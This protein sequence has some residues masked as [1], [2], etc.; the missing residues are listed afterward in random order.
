MQTTGAQTKKTARPLPARKGHW[1]LKNSLDIKNDLIGFADENRKHYGEIFR[2]DVLSHSLCFTTNPDHVKYILQENNRN[3]VKSFGYEILKVFLGNGLLTSEGDFWRKQRRLAQP[4]FHREKLAAITGQMAASTEKLV[5]KWKNKFK[6]GA[7]INIADE[8]NEVTLDIVAEALFGANVSDHLEEIREAISISNHFAMN[9]IKRAVRIPLWFP[10]PENI[11]FNAASKK[12][13]RIIYGIIEKRR[14]TKGEHNDLLSMLMEAKDEETGESMSD[15]QLRDEV[16]TIFIAGHE[17][18]AIALSWL[19]YLLSENPGEEEKLRREVMPLNGKTLSFEDIPKL[20]YTKQVVEETLRLY[21]PAWI[22]GRR[23]MEDDEV[24]GFLLPRGI[25]VLMLT[26]L[27]HRH[28]AYWENPEKFDPERFSPQKAGIIHKYSYFPFGGG[29]RLCIGN[30]FAM[31]EAQVIV[32]TI[33]RHFRL[34]KAQDTAPVMEPLITLRPKGGI[35][36]RLE[37]L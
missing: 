12:L 13:D 23:P 11:S 8:M 36:M 5:Q 27:V 31:M 9:R 21:P 20:K 10:T 33:L 30:N 15:L 3:Y 7:V 17:T 24:G 1:F 32:A 4:A 34:K 2:A 6:S 22:V 37:N 25:N 35:K 14:K 19:W 28:P 16:M 18:T 29:P 26:Y